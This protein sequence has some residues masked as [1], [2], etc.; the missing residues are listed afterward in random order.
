MNK[1]DINENEQLEN[2]EIAINEPTFKTTHEM[3]P[4]EK[5]EIWSKSEGYS[6]ENTE[7]VDDDL[8]HDYIRDN[9]IIK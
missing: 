5:D 9:Q 6:N 8:L 7:E 4:D 1:Y 3:T 2:E